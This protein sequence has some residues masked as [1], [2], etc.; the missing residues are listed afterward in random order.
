MAAHNRHIRGEREEVLASIKGSTVVEAGDLMFL[1]NSDGVVGASSSADNYAYPFSSAANSASVATG[2][3]EALYTQFLGVAMES[4]PSGT[5]ENI[6]IATDGVFKY[7]LYRIGAVTIGATVS[8]VSVLTSGTGVSD[9]VVFQ[10]TTAPGSTA[11]LGYIVKTESGASFVDFQIRTAFG[12][13]G[14]AT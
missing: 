5:T 10:S 4:S 14:L 13:S 9:Q 6:S 3:I 1:N 11:L 8:S 12:S 2:I 7:P